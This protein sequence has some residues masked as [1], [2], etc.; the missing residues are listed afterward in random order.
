MTALGCKRCTRHIMLKCKCSKMCCQLKLKRV[1]KRTR[2]SVAAFL[3]AFALSP[4]GPGLALRSLNS[5]PD[6]VPV[7]VWWSR[8]WRSRLTPSAPSN[9]RLVLRGCQSMQCIVPLAFNDSTLI[10]VVTI[11]TRPAGTSRTTLPNGGLHAV[12]SGAAKRGDSGEVLFFS[13]DSAEGCWTE[14]CCAP[15]L[16]D[17]SGQRLMIG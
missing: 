6:N 4:D 9:G 13:A 2:R 10:S 14:H 15:C 1:R 5:L 8:S 17:H 7:V 3:Q 12:I 11:P 16:S